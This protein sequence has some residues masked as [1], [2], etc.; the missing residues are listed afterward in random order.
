MYWFWKCIV[1]KEYLEN[2]NSELNIE[3]RYKEQWLMSSDAECKTNYYRQ[4]HMRHED[5]HIQNQSINDIVDQ[6]TYDWP[7]QYF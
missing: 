1:Q 5:T 7:F 3:I 2:E 6:T 4:E